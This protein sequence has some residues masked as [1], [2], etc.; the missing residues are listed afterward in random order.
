[1]PVIAKARSARDCSST[2]SSMAKATARLTA[3]SASISSAR[4]PSISVFARFE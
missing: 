4:T 1:M 2:P 3:P